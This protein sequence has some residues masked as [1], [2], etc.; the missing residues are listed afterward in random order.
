MTTTSTA[1]PNWQDAG[2]AILGYGHYYPPHREECAAQTTGEGV[3][4]AVGTITVKSRHRSSATE[5]VADMALQA[6]RQAIR[7][8]AVAPDEIDLL[9]LTNWTERLYVPDL[10]PQVAAA[11]G[12]RRG[13]A[14]DLCGACTGFVHGVQTAAAFLSSAGDWRTA[15]VVSADQFSRRVDPTRYGSVTLGDAA[16]AVVLR[17]G[18][19][20][21]SALLDSLLVSDGTRSGVVAV[22][23]ATGWIEVSPDL[24]R[25]AVPGQ[26]GAARLLLERNG[27]TI[28][29]IDWVVPHPGTD[30]VHGPVRE[31]IGVEP[32]RFVTNFPDRGNT[33]SASIPVVLSEYLE[34][35]PFQRGDLV[36]ALAV[37]S[38]WY[39]GGLLFRL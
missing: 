6:A 1:A 20:S 27:L 36:L 4:P 18:P 7:D 3:D 38:G 37:G 5:T 33:G 29:D 21:R 8:A 22:P 14:F 34:S 26:A 31:A 28:D 9:I 23:A 12:S 24:P 17:R 15:L 25:H 32:G 10:A 39:S 35:G 16:G 30:A 13:L 2:I 19:A 11:L